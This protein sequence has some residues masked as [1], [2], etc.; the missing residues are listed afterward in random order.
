MTLRQRDDGLLALD[1]LRPTEARSFFEKHGRL[2]AWRSGA[3]HELPGALE[4]VSDLWR[5]D[6]DTFRA[7]ELIAAASVLRADSGSDPTGMDLD[8]ALAAARGDLGEA[9]FRLDSDHSLA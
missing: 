4:A 9:P 5:R 6:G 3:L 8:A 2:M 1:I 7:V